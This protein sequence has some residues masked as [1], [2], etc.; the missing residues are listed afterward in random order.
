MK[1]SIV[2]DIFSFA[3]VDVNGSVSRRAGAGCVG[4]CADSEVV[5]AVALTPPASGITYRNNADG[6][7]A[8]LQTITLENQGISVVMGNLDF[9]PGTDLLFG[10]DDGFESVY[11]D[12]AGTMTGQ[13]RE[14]SNE[15]V[16]NDNSLA[17]IDGDG[18]DDLVTQNAVYRNRTVFFAPFVHDVSGRQTEFG[19]VDGDG[20]PDIGMN[21]YVSPTRRS[22]G[23]RL[24][25][26]NVDNEFVPDSLNT[27]E[28]SL[29]F[30]LV[31]LNGDGRV[32]MLTA[33]SGTGEVAV[34]WNYTTHPDACITADLADPR[35]VVD[36]SDLSTFVSGFLDGQV[37][38]DLADPRGTIDL[39]DL[40]R[41]VDSFLAGCP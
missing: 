5:V 22:L 19:D 21:F 35:G 27:Y 23:F 15:T 13:R 10:T 3:A 41:F 29:A 14:F 16:L 1:T 17:D 12:G 28:G 37:I 32:E 20:D 9:E 36:L 6:T 4:G 24:N 7:F 11:N 34:H 30:H 18:D 33:D 2:D 38:S 26:L 8:E 39:A 25:T 40:A 31:D